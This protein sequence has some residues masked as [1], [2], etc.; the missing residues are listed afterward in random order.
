[1]GC[2]AEEIE[3]PGEGQVRALVTI[4]SNPVLSAP[5]GGR[6]AAA[7][8]QL[9]LMVSVD[10]YLNETTRHAHVILPGRS[11][12]EDGHF[13]VAFP[14]LAWRNTARYSPP[15]LPAPPGHPAE[16]ELLLRL[17]A[18]AMGRG[19]GADLAALDDELA[20][21]D[22]ARVA[23][24]AAVGAVLAAVRGARGPERLIDLA[25]R[26]G[27]YGD[28]F[29][30]SPGG[31][32]LA[33]LRDAPA[34]IDLGELAPRLPEALR[35]PSGRIELAPPSLL[36]E[37]ARALADLDRPAPELVVIGRRHLRS[38]NSWMHNLPVLAKGPDRCVALVHPADAARL[39][40]AD[41]GRALMSRATAAGGPSIAVTI[42]VSDEVM[43]GVV[44]FPHGWGHDLPGS[45]LR[46]AA[47][48][49]GASLNAILDDGL[50]DPLSGTAALSGAP[51][52]LAPR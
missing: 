42:E 25:L 4:A 20:A 6:L 32:T 51:I 33:A 13:D 46:V 23:G 37:V 1:M 31:L 28:R 5:A 29:G 45:Q 34:G 11:P 2:L 18:I 35:T 49:P 52:T 48:R 44:S 19:A 9:E 30:A 22:V 16:W 43:P 15:V 50:R 36:A 21:A 47:A 39:G 3:V 40:L 41:G 38:N 26:G 14:Q 24:P 27:P 12:L 17:Q 7:L 8:D 10:V